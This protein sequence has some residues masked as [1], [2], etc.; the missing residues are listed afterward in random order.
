MLLKHRASILNP[1]DED[2]RRITVRRKHIFNNTIQTLKHVG[3]RPSQHLKI[4]FLGEPGE[5]DGGSR[6]EFFRLLFAEIA[7]NNMLFEGPESKRMPKHNSLATK[8]QLFFY[9]GQLLGL[10]LLNNGPCVE[11]LAP[12]IVHYI[13]GQADTVFVEDIPAA[14]VVAKVKMVSRS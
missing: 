12:T 11:W 14:D 3:W 8:D 1:D 10:S 5:D 13:F 7:A 4:I 2:V 6:R 9:I